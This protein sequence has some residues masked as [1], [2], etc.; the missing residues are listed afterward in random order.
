MIRNVLVT[1]AAGFIG[2]A[3]SKRLIA[4]GWRVTGVDNLNDYYDP[5]LKRDRLAD[6]GSALDFLLV[7]IADTEAVN[8][9]FA[10]K[11]FDVVINL[12]LKPACATRS[13]T[14]M[15]T[16]RAIWSGF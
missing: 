7:D 5:Q 8:K 9:L 1:G 10:D 14:L 12:R 4:E 6:I 13:R 2:A 3:V 16:P 11:K 15:P